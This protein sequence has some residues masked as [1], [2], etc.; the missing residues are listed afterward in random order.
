MRHFLIDTDTGSDDAVALV[1]ALTNPEIRVEA[2][3]VVAG[4]VPLEQ[5]VQNALYTVELTGANVPVYQGMGAPLLRPH[6]SAQHVHGSDGMG[7][8]GLDVYGRVPAPEHATDVLQETI[9]RYPGEITLV[10]LGPLTNVAMALLRDPSLGGK[11]S[12][13]VIMGGTGRGHGN[14]TPVA[15]YNIW[16]D[17]EA[18]QIVFE[19]GMPIT[20]VGWDVSYTYATLNKA[21]TDRLRAVG[22]PLATFCVDIQAALI[23]FATETAGLDGFDL[24]DPI[25]MAVAIDPSVVTKSRRLFVGIE[26]G[27]VWCRGQTV[28]DLLGVTGRNPNVE[29]VVEASRERFLEML[30]ES[31]TDRDRLTA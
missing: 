12:N 19:S 1:M 25:A 16:V 26:T 28:V 2:I 7:D 8:I 11:V 15:E 17:P 14:V 5:G 4:N 31:V 6:E 9:N 23:K 24:P 29:V 22:T 10:T 30:H 20:M 18:A 27:G 13:C 21:E 3:T